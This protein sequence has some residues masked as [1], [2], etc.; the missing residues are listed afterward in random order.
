MR[1]GYTGLCECV[2]PE[3]LSIPA[4]FQWEILLC[5][6]ETLN[7]DASSL[8]KT[9]NAR[10]SFSQGHLPGSQSSPHLL[11]LP[12]TFFWLFFLFLSSPLYLGWFLSPVV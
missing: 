8:E 4:R 2:K 11:P 7:E 12:V 3:P 5:L 10:S 6:C 9:V 1:S